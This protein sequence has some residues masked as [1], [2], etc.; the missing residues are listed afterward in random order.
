MTHLFSQIV[1]FCFFVVVKIFVCMNGE[2]SFSAA[3]YTFAASD[4]MRV[5]S[6]QEEMRVR[7]VFLSSRSL[8]NV[9]RLCKIVSNVL[10]LY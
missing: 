10:F 5:F 8:Y 1:L 9:A 2:L 3:I 4:S 6:H 7:W